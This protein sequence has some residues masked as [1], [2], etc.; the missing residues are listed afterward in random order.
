MSK[1]RSREDETYSTFSVL[2]KYGHTNT[3]AILYEIA[4]SLGRIADMLTEARHIVV[5][6]SE[7]E[8]ETE[9]EVKE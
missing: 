1:F 3:D 5:Y 8:G 6:D 4:I 7:N 9:R 2:S